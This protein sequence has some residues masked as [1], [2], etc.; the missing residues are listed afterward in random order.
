MG[1]PEAI[2]HAIDSLP[3]G[4]S[5]T[6]FIN[7]SFHFSIVVLVGRSATATYNGM[8]C[9]SISPP[10]GDIT[11]SVSTLILILR[12]FSFGNAHLRITRG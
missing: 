10:L 9:I 8:Y 11:L 7:G 5:F 2:T 1:I 3:V 6:R 12:R 4:K